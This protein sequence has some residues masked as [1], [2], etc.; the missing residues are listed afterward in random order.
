M[1]ILFVA[2]EAAPFAKVG[3]LGDVVAAGSLPTAL[4]EMNIDARVILPLYGAIKDKKYDKFNIRP[5][6]GFYFPRPTGTAYVQVHFTEVQGV[7]FYFVESWPFFGDEPMVYSDWDWDMPR[8]I[9]FSQV[10]M[11]VAWEIRQREGWFP[12]VFHVNDWHTGLVPFLI[13]NSGN[14]PLWANVRSMI[15]LHNVAYQGP[16]ATGWLME[17]EVPLRDHPDL[18]RMGLGD[19]LLAI[20]V[21]YADYVTTVSPRHADEIQYPYMGYGLDGLL[22]TRTYQN[23]LYGVLNGIDTEKFDP[24]TDPNIAHNYDVDTFVEGRRANK[25]QLQQDTGLAVRDDVPVIG[26]VSRIVRQKGLDL[27]IPALER[28]LPEQ[29]V[30]LVALGTGEP[31]LSDAL[32]RLGD[33]FPDKARVY[34]TYDPEIAQRIYAG[35]DMFLMPSHYEPCGIGQMI[36][37][38]YGALP[39]VRET[40][41]LADTVDNYD[42]ADAEQGT[43]FV[44]LWEQP[45][46]VLNTLRW[47]LETYRYRPQAWQRMQERA[48]QV[49]FSWQRSAD[50]YIRLYR[51]ILPKPVK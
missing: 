13:K 16:Y 45:E 4:R 23:R 9:F 5:L 11:A 36:A 30:Q 12:D 43:G 32:A 51:S 42:N 33:A 34:I 28:L 20:G 3:G 8:F 38:R 35:V 48:M 41:G 18:E 21:A 7:P 40:G 29:D 25:R 15:T 39:V 26:I 31:D 2:S 47:A 19:N 6:F 44:F 49:D 1:N 22:R 17:L 27:A 50:A 14:D 46:A 10:S 24:L 37:M